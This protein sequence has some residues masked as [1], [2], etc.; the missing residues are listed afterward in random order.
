MKGSN[1]VGFFFVK[2]Y[3][4]YLWHHSKE[5]TKEPLACD[6]FLVINHLT[7]ERKKKNEEEKNNHKFNKYM[8]T[9]DVF[10]PGLLS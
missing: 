2:V 6:L 9:Q 8:F 4:S 5:K 7:Q 3:I 10:F 1:T